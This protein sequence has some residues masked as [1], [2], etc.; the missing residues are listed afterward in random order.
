MQRSRQFILI[1]DGYDEYRKWT[2]LHTRNQFNRPR[3]WQAKMIISCRTQYVGPNYRNYFEP[4]TA[5]VDNPNFSHSSDLFEE[6]V[7]VPFRTT[8]INEYIELFTQGPNTMEY[9]GQDSGWSTEQY[10][11]RLK[12][13][14]HLMELAKNPFMLKMILDVLPTIAK[15]TTKMTR[16]ELYDRFVEFHFKSEQRRLKAQHFQWQDGQWNYFSLHIT[17]KR[18]THCSW[19]GSL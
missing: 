3:Q 18:G 5:T 6:A 17:P 2:N 15:S 19:T 8:Q 12:S 13:I 7:I 10:M 14:S 11:E 1:C 16:V 4:E 9:P